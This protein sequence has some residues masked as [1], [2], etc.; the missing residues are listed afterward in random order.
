MLFKSSKENIQ[1]D[2]A[3]FTL[4]TVEA[5]IHLPIE[6]MLLEAV[7]RLKTFFKTDYACIHFYPNIELGEEI[8]KSGLLSCPIMSA[9]TELQQKLLKIET[10][11]DLLA[12]SSNE[13]IRH[14]DALNTI[15]EWREFNEE[16]EFAEGVTVP[17]YYQNEV[18]AAINI[19]HKKA[20]VL[21][22]ADVDFLNVFGS[23]LYGAV[24]KELMIRELSN[25]DDLIEAFAKTIEASDNYTGGH[26]DRVMNYSMNIGRAIG[27][28]SDELRTLRRAA[29]LHDI[30]KIGVPSKILNKPGRLTDEER[31]VVEAHP[32]IAARIFSM[33]EE[34][35]LKK[36]LDG[37]I[38]HH[39]RI[40]GAGYPR[41]LKGD[42]IPLIARIIAIADTFDALTSDRP[43]RRGMELSAAVGILKEIKGSQLDSDLVDVFINKRLYEIESSTAPGV[44]KAG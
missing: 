10:Q 27:M 8:V 30:G 33:V 6:G 17:L 2:L 4:E 24:K 16:F 3:F 21:S 13:I 20:T 12:M 39:E 34:G 11:L 7:E 38:Y 23:C 9:P 31:K 29:L 15:P 5:I 36:S 28:T 37:I 44:K 19:Y 42:E 43:Y 40:D 18:Y 35:S 41:G 22:K 32:V 26:V 25:R 1:K 14:K